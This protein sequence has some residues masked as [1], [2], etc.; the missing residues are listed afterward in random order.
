MRLYLKTEAQPA[1]GTS[2]FKVFFKNYTIDKVQN[3]RI[4]CLWVIHRRQ[5]PIMLNKCV[6]SYCCNCP[7]ASTPKCQQ[8][9]SLSRNNVVCVVCVWCVFVFCVLLCRVCVCV[10]VCGV[11]VCL[12]IAWCVCVCIYVCMFE[13]CVYV[14]CVC[15]CLYVCV[16]CVCSYETCSKKDRTF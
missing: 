7:L 2:C 12:C 5:N 13:V 10:Y 3:T 1:S 14:C 15:M 4:W 6:Y 9:T 8:R 16:W 11:C